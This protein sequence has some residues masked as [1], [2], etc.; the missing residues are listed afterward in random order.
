MDDFGQAQDAPNSDDD[1]V[2]FL[3]DNPEAHEAVEDPVEGDD[4]QENPDE[5][6]EPDDDSESDDTEADAKPSKD[7]TTQPKVKVTIKGEDGADQ[8]V[9]VDQKELVAGYTRHADYTRKTQQ[10]SERERQAHEVVSTALENGR[11]HYL[12]EAQRAHAAIH[13]LAGL[14]SDTEMAQLA[15]SDPA[16]WVQEQQRQNYIRGVLGQLEQT[17]GAE[18]QRAEQQAKERQQQQAAEAWQ[19]LKAENIDTAKLQAIYQG[20]S[21]AYGV[22]ESRFDNLYDPKVILMMRDAMAYRD[23]T[24]KAKNRPKPEAVKP[25]RGLPSRQA[26]PQQTQRDRARDGRF[27]S[28][29]AKLGDLAS[30]I[31]EQKPR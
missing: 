19:V 22:P 16:G 23:L 30:F 24:E 10:L 6:G 7:Q 26:V 28:G 15:Q 8:E 3:M 18:M 5:G 12:Q 2:S 20:V 1:L 13:Q 21:K 11:K 27:K 14:K 4:D 31:L 17:A 9:E 29:S 25:S